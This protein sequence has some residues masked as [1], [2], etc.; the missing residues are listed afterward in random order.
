MKRIDGAEE[1]WRVSHHGTGN[2][3]GKAAVFGEKNFMA[4]RPAP[5]STRK[6][7]EKDCALRCFD[8]AVSLARAGLE[9]RRIA[10]FT[11]LFAH[12]KLSWRAGA[13]APITNLVLPACV[14]AAL[15]VVSERH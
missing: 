2:G 8:P 10:H 15:H 6:I 9:P 7:D 4:G 12:L 11:C 5:A 14:I 1:P 13:L 3:T